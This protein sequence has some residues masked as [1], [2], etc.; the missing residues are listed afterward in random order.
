MKKYI[1]MWLTL[2]L[3][4]GMVSLYLDPMSTTTKRS[5]LSIAYY[6]MCYFNC[7][8]MQHKL[9]HY[10]SEPTYIFGANI[11]YSF[12]YQ[13]CPHFLIICI[14]YNSMRAKTN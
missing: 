9:T 5:I 6:Y 8:V 7:K 1:L 3:C 11:F 12:K 13:P 14:D 2:G 4:Y 10:C